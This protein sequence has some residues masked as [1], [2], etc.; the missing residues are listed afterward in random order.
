MKK[1]IFFGLTVLLFSFTQ[2]IF[3]QEI[4]QDPGPPKIPQPTPTPDP[5]KI[6]K[7]DPTPNPFPKE[8][9]SEK[10]QRLTDENIKLKEQNSILESKIIELNHLIENLHKIIVEQGKVIMNLVS[11]LKMIMFDNP[12]SSIISF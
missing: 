3:A 8:S 10:I 12:L 9:E 1:N 11:K 5:I 4:Q 2:P 7:S 6:P